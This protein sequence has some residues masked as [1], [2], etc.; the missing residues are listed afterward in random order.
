MKNVSDWTNDLCKLISN[1][2]KEDEEETNFYIL[3]SFLEKFEKDI[4]FKEQMKI[5]D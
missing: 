3:F 5:Y 4:K 1:L 2:P